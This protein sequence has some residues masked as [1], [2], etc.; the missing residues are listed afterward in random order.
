MGSHRYWT[1]R[2]LFASHQSIIQILYFETGLFCDL[3]YGDTKYPLYRLNMRSNILACLFK[4][5]MCAVVC[6]R[7][8]TYNV[9]KG[10]RLKTWQ[11]GTFARMSHSQDF[12]YHIFTKL[13]L[14][15]YLNDTLC[16]QNFKELKIALYRGHV[17]TTSRQF[18]DSISNRK[19]DNG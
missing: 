18:V 10:S 9:R 11:R 2:Y 8:V 7:T 14:C 1:W 12:R 5:T 17:N 4:I 3:Y 6:F 19:P 13:N 15:H 16:F